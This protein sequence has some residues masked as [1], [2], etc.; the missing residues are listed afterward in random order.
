LPYL[1]FPS[2]LQDLEMIVVPEA[3]PQIDFNYLLQVMIYPRDDVSRN[4]MDHAG[5]ASNVRTWIRQAKSF[6]EVNVD[7]DVALM[8]AEAPKL[9]LEFGAGLHRAFRMVENACKK[10]I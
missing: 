7:A 2:E 3:I 5:I 4:R 8:L 6:G 1:V 10:S 9:E